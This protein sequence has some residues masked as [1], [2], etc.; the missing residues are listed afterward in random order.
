LRTYEALYIISTS[1]EDDGIQT[2]VNDV[3]SL[4]TK[5]GGTIVRSENWGRRKMAYEV[6]KQSEG[7]YVLL[8]FQ[9]SPE[10]VARLESY[11]KL[12]EAII[13]YIV[14]HFDEHTLQ[15]E[16]EQQRRR[17]EE[18][19]ASAVGRRRGDDDDDDEDDDDPIPVGAG[20]RSRR[21]QDEDDDE[22]ND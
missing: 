21:D 1:I 20:R 3:E 22:D 11:F 2:I 7:N 10:F 12:S 5:Q 6:K 8:R 9:A 15:L 16:A 17:E 19:R 14:V 18:I 13:R 4:V